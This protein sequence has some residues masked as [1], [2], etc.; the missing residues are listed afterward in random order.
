MKY[1]KRVGTA[2]LKTK[3][4]LPNPVFKL[5]EI[6]KNNNYLLYVVGGAVR[7]HLM[8][9]HSE[10]KHEIQGTYSPKDVDLATNARPREVES[11]LN[12]A[13]VRNFEKGESFGVWVAHIDGEDFEIATLREESGY[14][15]GR[16]PTKVY[17]V[18]A[19]SDYKRRDLTINALFYEIP[20]DPNQLGLV[21][22][23]GKGVGFEDI[24]SKTIRVVGCPFDRFGEDKLRILRLVRF[25]SRYHEGDILQ[26][27]DEKT[28]K[29]IEKFKDLRGN[30]VTG[31]RIQ[32]EFL[33]GL[34][35][36]WDTKSYLT[37]YFRLGL[38]PVVFP[39]LK[40]D[41]NDFNR[42]T[43]IAD[44]NPVVVL[45][46]MLRNNPH[47]V[48]RNKLN[49]L[50]WP[51]EISD[52]VSFLLKL[53]NVVE[54]WAHTDASHLVKCAVHLTN[55]R[56]MNVKVY[57]LILHNDV[58]LDV[59]KHFENYEAPFYSGE[60]IEKEFGIAP[61]PEMGKK[62]RELQL[63]H[64]NDSFGLFLRTNKP[65]PRR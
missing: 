60:Y 52:E 6:F 39:G 9:E 63:T 64:Y 57:G 25:F 15:D 54:H 17:W 65:I 42:L 62:Q 23:F 41:F 21:V 34:L 10:S 19:A 51:N 61:G 5:S 27:L 43:A 13:G 18:D 36:S 20:T 31:P 26:M 46:M 2:S 55:E 33:A 47:D 59:W 14:H 22:D 49:E 58:D 11:I 40:I 28:V 3:I 7:D 32:Q 38:L 16:H 53:T 1:G 24:M 4:V 56:R 8:F 30:G 29:A 45:A 44:K 35:K 48:V 50:N 12:A 37:N